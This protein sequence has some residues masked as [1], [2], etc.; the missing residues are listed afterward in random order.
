[1]SVW[2]A[3]ADDDDE[4]KIQIRDFRCYLVLG[5]TVASQ[6]VRYPGP[7][8]SIVYA[9]FANMGRE[10][11]SQVERKID[12]GT[13]EQAIPYIY[14]EASEHQ[15][16]FSRLRNT[17]A[18]VDSVYASTAHDSAEAECEQIAGNRQ[19][20]KLKLH[21]ICGISEGEVRAIAVADK[22]NALPNQ[23]QITGSLRLFGRTSGGGDFRELTNT[24]LSQTLSDYSVDFEGMHYGQDGLR[25][26]RAEA[27]VQVTGSNDQIRER[28]EA[29][30]D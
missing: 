17:V 18:G 24:S 15:Q 16:S 5:G 19:G 27:Q 12:S 13:F 6:F 20:F 11:N 28:E 25:R 23:T 29:D 14:Y 8:Y 9:G 10:V 21:L 2:P 1:M 7:P 22:I 26:V 4:L 3:S 30:C